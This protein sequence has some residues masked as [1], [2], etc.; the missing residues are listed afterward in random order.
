M[1]VF[2]P[3]SVPLHVDALEGERW[4]IRLIAA[5]PFPLGELMNQEYLHEAVTSC[6]KQ[7]PI[8]NRIRVAARWFAEA[9]YSIADDD[10]ALALGVAMDSMLTG[11][12]ALAGSVMADRF[13]L[14]AEDPRDRRERAKTY[15]D[16]YSVRS[17]VA[18][19]GRSSKLDQ[20]DFIES[21][22]EFVRWAA[23]RL[24][25]VQDT[26]APSSEKEIDAL[27]D[28]LRWGIRTWP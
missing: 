8:S 24:L 21:Y 4:H 16:Y 5:E 7:N 6:L 27:F 3:A 18:H 10:A 9:H 23:W 11:Q 26:F 20:D 15:L 13:A 25:A 22:L 14:L 12:R 28:D 1:P 2:E 17:S 19:G